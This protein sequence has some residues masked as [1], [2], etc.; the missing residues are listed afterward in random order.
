[1]ICASR[2]RR[3]GYYYERRT[4]PIPLT[5]WDPDAYGT[6]INHWR[7]ETRPTYPSP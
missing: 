3:F 4:H 5:A 6:Y 2:V 1:M 7:I